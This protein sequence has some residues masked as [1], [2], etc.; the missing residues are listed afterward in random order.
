MDTK[1]EWFC[2]INSSYTVESLEFYGNVYNNTCLIDGLVTIPHTAFLLL[3]S[4]VLLVVGCFTSYR[5]VH[6][7]Y[8]LVYPGHSLRWL[9]SVLLLII[10]LASIGEGIM[11]DETYQAWKQPTQPHLYIHSIVA[12]VAVVISLVYYHHMELWQLPAMSVLLLVY[13]VFSLGN[14]VL[15]MLNLGLQEDVDVHVV[16]FDLT[17]IKLAIYSVLIVLEMNVIREKVN[18]LGFIHKYFFSLFQSSK[19]LTQKT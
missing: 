13:W 1:W 10:I 19:N 11:T 6:T 16:I 12:F 4:V 17:L 8:L 9:V 5:R 2:G 3:A 15:R 14:E 18:L 7:K